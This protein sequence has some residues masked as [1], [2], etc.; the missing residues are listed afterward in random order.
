MLLTAL[1]LIDSMVKNLVTES[2]RVL[3]CRRAGPVESIRHG[4][5]AKGTTNSDPELN[6]LRST[7]RGQWFRDVSCPVILLQ[8]SSRFFFVGCVKKQKKSREKLI[9]KLVQKKK[10][11]LKHKKLSFLGKSHK[12]LIFSQ[13]LCANLECPDVHSEFFQNFLIF[14]IYF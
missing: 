5:A 8:R 1:N 12:M 14:Q 9:L 11:I 7:L 4:V 3:S 13:I 2:S 10:L 6:A